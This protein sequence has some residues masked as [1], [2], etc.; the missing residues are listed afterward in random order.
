MDSNRGATRTKPQRI[1]AQF[2]VPLLDVAQVQA[3]QRLANEPTPYEVA[4][5]A[6]E[7]LRVSRSGAS[8]YRGAGAPIS[9][10]GLRWATRHGLEALNKL[11]QTNTERGARI[12]ATPS[13]RQ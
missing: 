10:R 12:V 5:T 13:S 9:T 4:V 11:A 6:F 2:E 8:G 3:P 7:S 1:T